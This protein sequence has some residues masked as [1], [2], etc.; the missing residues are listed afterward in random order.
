MEGKC[1]LR[2]QHSAKAIQP[3]INADNADKRKI[4]RESMQ[5]TR[6]IF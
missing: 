1:F 2:K 4:S 6:I 3:Q 5:N